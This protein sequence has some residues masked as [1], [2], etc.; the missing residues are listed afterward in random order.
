MKK[1][2]KDILN[3]YNAIDIM[4][5]VCS[6][7]ICIIHIKPFPDGAFPNSNQIN[8][9]FQIYICRIAVPFYFISSGFF[10]FKKIDINN[11]N[12]EI[13]KKYCFKILKLL[14]IWYVILLNT[15]KGQLW[16]LGSLVFSVFIIYYLLIK[17]LSLK[18]IIIISI[19]LY[20]IGLLGDSYYG[21]IEPLNKFKL[22]GY[23]SHFYF[24]TFTTTRNGLFFGFI[25]V[26][27]G[28]LFSKDKIK[29]KQNIS[30]ILFLVS[31]SL[32]FFEVLIL[33]KLSIPKDYNLYL[34]LIPAT[35]FLFSFLYQCK[36]KDNK[37]FIKLRITGMFIFYTHLFINYFVVKLLILLNKIININLLKYNFFITMFAVIL[38][39]F[40]LEELSQK[41]RFSFLKNLYK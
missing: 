10:L 35:I 28:L 18:K 16:Y 9:L 7:L 33:K 1:R 21:L 36:I 15:N 29:I 12:K 3:N 17:K 19:L 26:L 20:I 31:F 25:F 22:F 13:I 32:L 5:F 30:L 39:S 8:L 2:K 41:D 23:L 27:I 37:I 24:N 38:I 40:I 11:P 6:I 14:G 4:K 34:L